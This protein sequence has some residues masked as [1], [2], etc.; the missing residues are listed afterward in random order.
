MYAYPKF[1]SS[2]R[3]K[4]IPLTFHGMTKKITAD[5]QR[6]VRVRGESCSMRR[7]QG[8]WLWSRMLGEPASK[9]LLSDECNNLWQTQN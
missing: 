1:G 4:N 7:Q 3:P 2:R 8:L 6:R 9:L 5:R